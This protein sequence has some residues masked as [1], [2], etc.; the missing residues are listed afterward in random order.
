MYF[1][2]TPLV[3]ENDQATTMDSKI[4]NSNEV[5]AKNVVRLSFE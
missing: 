5:D 3:K 2:V 1:L 4:P